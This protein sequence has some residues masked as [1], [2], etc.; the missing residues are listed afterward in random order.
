MTENTT[1]TSTA[2]AIIETVGA[3][4]SVTLPIKLLQAAMAC[5]SATETPGVCLHSVGDSM[6]VVGMDSTRVFV[7]SLAVDGDMPSWLAD[8]GVIIPT[9]GLKSRLS[10]I[11]S[12]ARDKFEPQ[13]PGEKMPDPTVTVTF[14][15]N[16]DKVTIQNSD[17]D[18]A[19]KIAPMSVKFPNYSKLI[20]K[21]IGAFHRSD[22]ASDF[23]ATPFGRKVLQS[24]SDVARVLGSDNIAI[25]A[26]NGAN[27]P[28]V[29][30]LGDGA[31]LYLVP[32]GYSPDI[33]P[34]AQT[35]AIL[36]PAIKGTIAALKANETRKRKSA[37]TLAKT[38]P[39]ESARLLAQAN[40]IK[41]R[42]RDLILRTDPSKAIA[43]P[44]VETKVESA[45]ETK[46]KT[47]KTVK[48]ETK[49]ESAPKI[50]KSAYSVWRHDVNAAVVAELKVGLDLLPN[51]PNLKTMFQDG[52]S[53]QDAAKRAMDI[54]SAA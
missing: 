30:T 5:T 48:T 35:L 47:V 50:I 16:G 8:G 37:V 11:M 44:V 38:D 7:G 32:A 15:A 54:A 51:L 17:S 21:H 1:S 36:A 53:A 26:S 6:R 31:V 22:D 12:D 4:E 19:F 46:V 52:V 20:A 25:Y 34:H 33:R 14:A 10:L 24:A 27:D 3:P 45:P 41:A 2:L 49:I 28:T 18:I 39:R 9:V 29:C 43:A 23:T 13:E 42:I 40:D